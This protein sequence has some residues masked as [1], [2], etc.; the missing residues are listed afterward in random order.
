[1]AATTSG[2]DS[3]GTGGGPQQRSLLGNRP[4]IP[5][6]LAVVGVALLVIS[7][8]GLVASPNQAVYQI[9]M[10]PAIGAIFLAATLAVR[11]EETLTRVLVNIGLALLLV[12]LVV[13]GA[14][15]RTQTTGSS[16]QAQCALLARPTPTPLPEATE[17]A[18]T[19]PGLP[20][21]TPTP[22]ARKRKPVSALQIAAKWPGS[23][24]DSGSDF[25]GITLDHGI[26]L[27]AQQSYRPSALPTINVGG[28]SCVPPTRKTGGSPHVVPSPIPVG[29]AGV[30]VER[31]FG[32]GYDVYAIAN[33]AAVKFD[34]TPNSIEWQ[35]LDQRI[36]EWGWTITPKALGRQVIFFNVNLE[37]RP[38]PGWRGKATRVT[39]ERQIWESDPVYIDVRQQQVTWGQMQAMPLVSTT[40]GTAA[41]A[42][43]GGLAN[44]IWGS[45]SKSEG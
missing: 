16:P 28:K 30:T 2:A 39:R 3:G 34:V 36:D 9:A 41:V 5:A 19:I 37:W 20:T 25:V 26:K 23:M 31:A 14:L 32:P 29:T 6:A 21:P 13:V 10:I 7:L 38:Q 1:M 27:A 22:V 4:W 43:L 42:L 35:S 8:I 33:L 44:K 18:R 40:V 17:L 12:V 45:K 15:L 24:E 11:N